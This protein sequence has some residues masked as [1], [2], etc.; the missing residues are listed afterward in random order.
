MN[1]RT[2]TSSGSLPVLSSGSRTLMKAGLFHLLLIWCPVQS[3]SI[4]WA[5]AQDLAL[6]GC[7]RPKVAVEASKTWILQILYQRLESDCPRTQ[8]TNH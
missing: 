2:Q 7:A 3:H 6:S 1:R 4:T 5:C 8:S